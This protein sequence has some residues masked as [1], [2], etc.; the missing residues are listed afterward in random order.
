MPGRRKYAC[1]EWTG[2]SPSV[3]RPAATSAWPATCPPKTRCRDSFG[4]RPRKILTSICSRSSRSTRRSA[5]FVIGCSPVFPVSE[6]AD[7]GDAYN[8][9]AFLVGGR[10]IDLRADTPV[11]VAVR[12]GEDLPDAPQSVL[13]VLLDQQQLRAPRVRPGA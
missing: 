5:G 11:M 4:L 12:V 9:P 10:Q 13:R 8:G 2:R 3:V 7:V 1:S 6:L